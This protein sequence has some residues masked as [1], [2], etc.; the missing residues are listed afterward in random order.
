MLTNTKQLF[1]QTKERKRH[2]RPADTPL[3]TYRVDTSFRH[4]IRHYASLL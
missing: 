2:P 1:I 4:Y 3:E